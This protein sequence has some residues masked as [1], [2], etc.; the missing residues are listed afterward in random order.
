MTAARRDGEERCLEVALSTMERLADRDRLLQLHGSVDQEEPRRPWFPLSM[1]SG[2]VG[3]ALAF[4]E[5]H[6]RFPDHGWDHFAHRFLKEAVGSLDRG[7]PLDSS[8]FSGLAGLAFVL[9]R[10]AYDG[11]Y[12]KAL[13]SVDQ[14]LFR[15]VE[16]FLLYLSDNSFGPIAP[17]SYDL[18]SGITGMG[19]YLLSAAVASQDAER[20]LRTILEY[21]ANR[22]LLAAGLGFVTSPCL[23][24]DWE[25]SLTPDKRTVYIDMGLAHGIAGPLALLSLAIIE[26]FGTSKLREA[27]TNLSAWILTQVSPSAEGPN[28]PSFLHPDVAETRQASR[29]AWCYGVPGVAAALRLAGEALGDPYLTR[30]STDLML[31]VLHRSP[32][33]LAIPSAILCHGIGGLLTI[34]KVFESSTDRLGSAFT[35]HTSRLLEDIVHQFDDR[36]ELGFLDLDPRHGWVPKPGLLEGSAGI[37]LALLEATMPGEGVTWKRAFLLC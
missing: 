7:A 15:A 6:A 1:A 12:S 26:G 28:I 30:A 24:P 20:L 29:A 37:A 13:R 32:Q 33:S 3:L 35:G 16:T 4:G 18:I 10:L 11:R 5:F 23:V 36:S 9:R 27:V 8:L 31:S 22:A 34:W 19:A 14:I 25:K 17:R 21:L 2:D